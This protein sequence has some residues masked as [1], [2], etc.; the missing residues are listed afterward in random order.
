M[1]C[2]ACKQAI[3]R[4]NPDIKW[5]YHEKPTTISVEEVREQLVKDIA[6]KPYSSKYKIYIIDEAENVNTGT[7]RHIEN[8]RGTAFIWNNYNIGTEQG[9]DA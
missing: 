6:I 5:I 4:N 1:E 2:H 3:S 8:N 7:E 9:Y